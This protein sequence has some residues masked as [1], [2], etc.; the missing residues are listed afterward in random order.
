VGKFGVLDGEDMHRVR[1]DD[2]LTSLISEGAL[3]NVNYSL[4][5]HAAKEQRVSER[6]SHLSSHLS[7]R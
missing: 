6:Q 1:D 3:L 5:L 7:Y 2:P 4:L